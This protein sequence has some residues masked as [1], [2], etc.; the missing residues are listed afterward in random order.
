MLGSLKRKPI[1]IRTAWLTGK[2]LNHHLPQLASR[3]TGNAGQVDPHLPAP[4]PKTG[5]ERGAERSVDP[6]ALPTIDSGNNPVLTSDDVSDYGWVDF[7]ADPFLYPGEDR[8]HLFFEVFNRSRNPDAVIGHATSTDGSEWNYQGVVLNAGKHLSFPYLF[9]WQ[10]RRYMLPETGGADDTMVELY[11]AVEF[12]REWRR[13]AV[14]V[15]EDHGTDDA[16]VFRWNDRWWLFVGD[17]SIAGANLY[18]SR[19]LHREDWTPHP[20]NPVVVDRPSASRPA[21]RPIVTD[22]RIVFFYQ[23]CANQYGERVRA[24]EITSLDRTT[25][26][27]RELLHSPIVGGTGARFGWN[28]GRMHHVDPWCIDG[29]W[30]CA[31]DGNVA[32]SDVFTN[33]HWA[34]GIYVSEPT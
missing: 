23:D 13:R 9:E 21:G 10:G 3:A 11:E 1:V 29:R 17:D 28:S 31:V 34:I 2:A 15:S 12:P 26:A 27:D 16:V 4:R 20:E 30:V 25:F 8:W 19:S 6:A 18:H 33:D 24:Y 5:T 7:V 22:D 14:L 32:R